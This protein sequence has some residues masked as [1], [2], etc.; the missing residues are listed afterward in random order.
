MSGCGLNDV[1]GGPPS[2]AGN[3]PSPAVSGLPAH[4]VLDETGDGAH[5][6]AAF[7]VAAEWTVEWSYSCPNIPSPGPYNQ[8]GWGFSLYST[9]DKGI[10]AVGMPDFNWS[11]QTEHGTEHLHNAGTFYIQT[12]MTDITP[13]K[14]HLLVRT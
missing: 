7:G 13:C 8:Y 2:Q 11:A 14:W 6:T 5:S 1:P 3:G 9:G 4:V 12:R 10:A